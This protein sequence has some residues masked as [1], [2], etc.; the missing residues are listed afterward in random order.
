MFSFTTKVK[1]NPEFERKLKTAQERA[2]DRTA[3]AW[4]DDLRLSGTMP[5]DTGFLQNDSTFV[6]VKGMVVQIISSTPYAR[7]LYFHPEYNFR[8]DKNPNAG[9]RWFDPYLPGHEKG[10]FLPNTFAKFLNEELGG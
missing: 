8:Q 1:I 10:D 6:E 2:I 9:G 7:R 5:L 3:H 4:L